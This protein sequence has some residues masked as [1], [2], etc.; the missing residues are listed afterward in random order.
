[1]GE[2]GGRWVWGRVGGGGCVKGCCVYL[3]CFPPPQAL[4]CLPASIRDEYS[5][6]VSSPILLVEQLIMDTK[7]HVGGHV[8]FHFCNNQRCLARKCLTGSNVH[9]QHLRGGGSE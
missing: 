6:L 4:L 8:H 1:M 5:C 7:V 9:V 2:T 3:M